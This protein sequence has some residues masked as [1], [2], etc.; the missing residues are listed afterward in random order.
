MVI[1]KARAERRAALLRTMVRDDDGWSD[2]TICNV[3][4]RGMMLRG[5]RV[6]AR[7]TIIEIRSGSTSIVADVRWSAPGQCGVRSREV[8]DVDGLLRGG[9]LQAKRQEPAGERRAQVR[10]VDYKTLADRSR[11]LGR[12]IDDALI[13]V[14]VVAGAV[15]LGAGVTGFLRNPFSQIHSGLASSR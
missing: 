5:S 6:P 11:V 3:S 2:M 7:G 13:A 12:L 14:L 9:S 15:L 1:G 4:E 8:I 10:P